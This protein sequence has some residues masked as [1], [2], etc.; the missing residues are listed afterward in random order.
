MAMTQS[1]QSMRFDPQLRAK[2]PE[3]KDAIKAFTRHLTEQ[4]TGLGL[5][6]RARKTEDRRKFVLTVE[7][8]TCNLLLLGLL[9]D[10]TALAAP[11]DNNMMWGKTR[12]RN[13]IYGQHFL[14]LL[15]LLERLK[16]IKRTKTGYRISRTNKSSSLFAVS[17][18]FGKHFPKAT[19]ASFYREQEPEVLILKEGKDGDDKAAL[20]N[21]RDGPNTRKLR[22]Q[23]KRL[24]DYLLDADIQIANA[25]ASVRLDRN[26][27][28]I[29]T[30]R[31]TLRRTFNNESWRQGGRL[32]GGFWMTMPRKDRFQRIRIDGQPV[33]DVDYQ[34]LFPRLAY[35]RARA[36]Q[37]KGDLY[38]VIGDGTGRDGWKVL[39]NALLFTKGPLKGWPRNCKQH[40]PD[41]KLTQAIEH[42]KKKHAPISNL[43]GTGLG[44]TLMF[45]ESEM[46]I[47]TVLHLFESGIPA[48]PLHDAVLVAKPHAK[49][50]KAAMEAAF[51]T[52]TGETRAFVKIDSGP[53]K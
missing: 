30:Y 7:A 51:C 21:Y 45:A 27:E 38:D 9:R 33:V 5:R 34:Q 37:P 40:F 29:A 35:V 22:N 17:P 15:N 46:L 39:L 16:L 19:L 1:N 49:A 25:R 47:A 18:N 42:I 12:Y 10:S 4:E 11:L 2:A 50:A 13:P 53:V 14:A 3:L 43:F 31:R 36:P 52:A 20:V 44:F 24:N 41:L 32:S 23:V 48:L 26:G 8:L 6:T 28:V